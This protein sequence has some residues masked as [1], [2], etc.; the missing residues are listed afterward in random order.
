MHIYIKLSKIFS[1]TSKVGSANLERSYRR[2]PKGAKDAEDGQVDGVGVEGAGICHLCLCG[3]GI[4]W[5]DLSLASYV[6]PCFSN[7]FQKLFLYQSYNIKNIS[8]TSPGSRSLL[9]VNESYGT[10]PSIYLYMTHKNLVF[11]DLFL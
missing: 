3:Q 8:C 2:A 1:C 9:Q 6:D 11:V 5:E 10:D 4:D 7:V